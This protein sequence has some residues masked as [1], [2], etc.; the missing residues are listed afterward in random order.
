MNRISRAQG[1]G[2]LADQLLCD[3]VNLISTHLTFP[4]W[5][6]RQEDFYDSNSV[7]TVTDSFFFNKPIVS[8]RNT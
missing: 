7:L 8:N 3:L 4:V 6:F 5:E 1:L 2:W